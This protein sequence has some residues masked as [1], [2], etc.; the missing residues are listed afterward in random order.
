MNGTFNLRFPW[1]TELYNSKMHTCTQLELTF[2]SP[3]RLKEM[4]T[5]CS[6][7]SRGKLR[8]SQPEKET[9][10]GLLYISLHVTDINTSNLGAL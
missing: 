9:H 3:W 4:V 7:S 6:H 8:F 1:S 10:E 2:N 5:S